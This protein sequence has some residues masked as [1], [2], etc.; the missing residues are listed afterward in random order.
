MMIQYE[1][2]LNYQLHMN[3]MSGNWER[4]PCGNLYYAGIY[5]HMNYDIDWSK[6]VNN[7]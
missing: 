2:Y 4:L 6:D 5:M 7:N 3:M 1:N